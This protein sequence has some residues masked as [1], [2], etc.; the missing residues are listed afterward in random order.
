MFGL[1]S[2]RIWFSDLGPQFML[3]T[4]CWL[5]LMPCVLGLNRLGVLIDVGLFAMWELLQQTDSWE[6]SI[7]GSVKRSFSCAISKWRVLF[8]IL[9]SVSWKVMESLLLWVQSVQTELLLQTCKGEGVH[10]ALFRIAMNWEKA[11]G[12]NMMFLPLVKHHWQA[13]YPEVVFDN[14]K[15]IYWLMG[16]TTDI[17]IWFN[18][19][20]LWVINHTWEVQNSHYDSLYHWISRFE[21]SKDVSRMHSSGN[22]RGL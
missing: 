8:P 12:E 7:C 6:H 5:M 15:W 17:F 9:T 10:I 22:R 21:N 11:R 1:H 16:T 14:A 19:T 2:Q 18:T 13:C 4:S 20:A 3:W